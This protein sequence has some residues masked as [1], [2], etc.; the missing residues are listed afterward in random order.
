MFIFEPLPKNYNVRFKRF[1]NSRKEDEGMPPKL[2]IH[3]YKDLSKI[4]W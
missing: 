4:S 3:S 1:I 2:V